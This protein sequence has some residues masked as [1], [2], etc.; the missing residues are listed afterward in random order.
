MGDPGTTP[1]WD[2]VGDR[3]T[4]LGRT[5][6][7]RWAEQREEAGDAG[8]AAADEVRGAIDGVRVS[9]DEL[10]HTITRTVNDPGVHDA[11]RA[12]AGGLVEALSSSLD[13]LAGKIQPKRD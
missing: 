4:Q 13:D 11:A 10:A 3:F 9:L 12:A 8:D 2:E 7:G 5:L 6:Q 1:R